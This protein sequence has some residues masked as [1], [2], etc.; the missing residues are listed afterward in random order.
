M[1]DADAEQEAAGVGLLD[2][3]ERL[4]DGPASAVQMLTMPVASFSVVVG[5]R[6]GST[7]DSSAAGEPPAQIAP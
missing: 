2:A 6:M 3:V 4:G 7:H 1:A 5:S